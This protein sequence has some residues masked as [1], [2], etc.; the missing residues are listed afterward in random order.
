M[1]KLGSYYIDPRVYNFDFVCGSLIQFP[2]FV[3][4]FIIF[5][6]HFFDFRCEKFLHSSGALVTTYYVLNE[7]KLAE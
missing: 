3:T 6:I 7:E 2:L 4:N 5:L 1:R